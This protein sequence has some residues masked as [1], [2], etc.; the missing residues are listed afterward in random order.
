MGITLVKICQKDEVKLMLLSVLPI[1]DR[2]T[3]PIIATDRLLIIEYAAVT[4][5]LPPSK[6]ATTG[7]DV[8]VEVKTHI[9]AA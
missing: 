9:I 7:A 8:A 5:M 4:E 1:K 3:G 6:P 2:K